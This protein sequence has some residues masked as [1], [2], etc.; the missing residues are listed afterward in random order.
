MSEKPYF[1]IWNKI[2]PQNVAI[3][4]SLKLPSAVEL[5]L[6]AYAKVIL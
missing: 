6:P 2:S 5:Y 3:S 1:S 4:D